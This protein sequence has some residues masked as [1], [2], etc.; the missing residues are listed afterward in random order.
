MTAHDFRTLSAYVDGELDPAEA[1]RIARLVATDER[2]ARE[3]ARLHEMKEAMADLA[4]DMVMV[5]VAAPTKRRAPVLPLAAAAMLLA[6]VLAGVFWAVLPNAS[7]GLDERQTALL[8]EAG[9]R[10]DAWIGR[11]GAAAP[12]SAAPGFFAPELSAA[13]LMLAKVEEEV[14]IAGRPATHAGYA[15]ARG[16]RLSLFEMSLGDAMPGVLTLGAADRLLWASWQTASARYLMVARNM[17]E[18][19][20]ATIAGVLRS[21]TENRR[22]VDREV[23]AQLESA[24]QPCRA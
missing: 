17:D 2:V 4:P 19:R 20:F 8:T 11:G 24:R 7:A 10:H 6:V 9:L 5:H 16:C 21:M 3:V 14:D 22:S 13:G 23:V 15:G 1:A 18:T 12:V